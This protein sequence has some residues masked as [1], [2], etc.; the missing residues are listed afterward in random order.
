MTTAEATVQAQLDAYN[1][2]DI[3]AYLAVFADDAKAYNFPGLECTIDGIEAMRR[4]Y[5]TVFDESPQLHCQ[6]VNR[7]VMDNKV[8]DHEHVTGRR[9]VDFL[10]LVA[11]YEVM[12]GKI[13]TVYF[14]RK[15]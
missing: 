8:F 10:E 1:A 5:Q 4:V 15:T 9:G 14:A 7:I 12:D 11:I 3:E 2:R 13:Q 6:L